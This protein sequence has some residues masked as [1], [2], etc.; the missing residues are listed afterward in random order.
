MARQTESRVRMGVSA[1]K[2]QNTLYPEQTQV[3]DQINYAEN[4]IATSQN[5]IDVANRERAESQAIFEEESA[6]FSD[7]I[8]AVRECI[9][10]VRGMQSGTPSL[11]DIKYTRKNARHLLTNLKIKHNPDL[12]LVMTLFQ[13]TQNYADAQNVQKMLDLLE[14]LLE[15]FMG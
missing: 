3:Q 10:L 12:T 4:M 5:N 8:D 9:A 2:L 7:A 15:N 14:G 1:Q 13:T 6:K 11:V